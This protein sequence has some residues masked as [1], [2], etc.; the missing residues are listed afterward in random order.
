MKKRGQ[1]S[2]FVILAVVFVAAIALILFINVESEKEK[3]GR[4]YFLKNN[5][6][7]SL[8][9]IQD[10]IL[11]CHEEVSKA[12]LDYIGIRGGYYEV[13]EKHYTIN[14]IMIPYYYHQGEVIKPD[15]ERIGLEL[16]NY[17][18]DNINNCLDKIKFLNFNLDYDKSETKVRIDKDKVVINTNFPVKIENEAEITNFKLSQYEL[19]LASPL[20]RMLEIAD[21]VTESSKQDPDLICLSCLKDYANERELYVDLISIDDK[22]TLIMFLE[23]IKTEEKPYIFQFINKYN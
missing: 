6:Q 11:E 5:L 1:V 10:F 18:D 22:S 16:S 20:Y 9:N 14:S 15:H 7:P 3:L 13:S 17:V 4:D 2:I 8:K 12:G 19:S 23:K 21:F